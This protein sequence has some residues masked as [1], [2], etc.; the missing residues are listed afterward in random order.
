V[1]SIGDT[2]GA[3]DAFGQFDIAEVETSYAGSAVHGAAKR[4]GELIVSGP[5]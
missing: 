3:R 2:P 1:L 4:A 5:G